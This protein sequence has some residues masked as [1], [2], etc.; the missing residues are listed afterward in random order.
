MKDISTIDLL[1]L[2]EIFNE[3]EEFEKD[4]D[5]L[6][7][8]KNSVDILYKLRMLLDGEKLLYSRRAKKF[9]KKHKSTL[10]KISSLTNIQT[11]VYHS[12]DWNKNTNIYK[13]LDAHRTELKKIKDIVTQIKFLGIEKI[14]LDENFD[15]TLKKYY[16]WTHL[17]DNT[18]IHYLPN[19]EAISIAKISFC[20]P[21]KSPAAATNLTSP[22]PNPSFLSTKIAPKY[23]PAKSNAPLIPPIA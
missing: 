8:K 23:R 3:Y 7:E 2:I 20:Q 21:S 4:L 16:M 12:I 14:E 18:S 9:Y 19:I 11:F 6:L 22:Q 1:V 17:S 5:K 13:Y 10:H 15:F